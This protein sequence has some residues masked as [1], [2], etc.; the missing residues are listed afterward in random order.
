MMK[1]GKMI[2]NALKKRYEANIAEADAVIMEILNNSVA[3]G[4]H[5]AKILEDLDKAI[6]KKAE[7]EDKIN[8]LQ[9]FEKTLAN[10]HTK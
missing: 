7:N 9:D 3:V 6:T 2:L 1:K 4:E 5:T 8:S 10:E